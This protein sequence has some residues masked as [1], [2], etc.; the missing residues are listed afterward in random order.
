MCV[1]DLSFALSLPSS[2]YL[3]QLYALVKV[4]RRRSRRKKRKSAK[5]C[6]DNHSEPLPE[7]LAMAIEMK[8]KVS[9]S[10]LIR[11][12][13]AQ[14][15]MILIE[16][17]SRLRAIDNLLNFF[18]QT[19]KKRRHK[20]TNYRSVCLHGLGVKK[21]E[22]TTGEAGKRQQSQSERGE[23][24]GKQ[25]RICGRECATDRP[26]CILLKIF[27]NV[28]TFVVADVDAADVVVVVGVYMFNRSRCF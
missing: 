26:L 16:I 25:E 5:K 15:H 28:V 12:Y 10:E 13:W 1:H 23:G 22:W 6:G 14:T 20:R 21:R 7:R 17:N 19:R 24:E 11:F 4:Y 3:C 2:L 27:C 8:I 18:F 9:T